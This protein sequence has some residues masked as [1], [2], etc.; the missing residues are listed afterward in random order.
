MKIYYLY[1]QKKFFKTTT[2][3]CECRPEERVQ[4]LGSRAMVAWEHRG[5]LERPT[6]ECWLRCSLAVW[7]WVRSVSYLVN[8]HLLSTNCVPGTMLE[9]RQWPEHMR[10]FLRCRAGG[11]ARR[12]SKHI[13]T[14]VSSPPPVRGDCKGNN[15]SLS[16]IGRL[17]HL[18]SDIFSGI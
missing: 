10:S 4:N 1:I 5:L 12:H 6:L 2:E 18:A 13:T 7:L 9:I 8:K 11:V 17:W 3:K 14:P 15:N 16:W